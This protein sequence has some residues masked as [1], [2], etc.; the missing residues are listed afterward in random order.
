M[1]LNYM[2]T[3]QWETLD[4]SSPKNLNPVIVYT[5]LFCGEGW[6]CV[7]T[8]WFDVNDAKNVMFKYAEE[9]IKFEGTSRV[10][11]RIKY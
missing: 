11:N 6:R 10:G 2:R 4:N 5:H 8:L 1:Y 9:Q 3:M 7:K